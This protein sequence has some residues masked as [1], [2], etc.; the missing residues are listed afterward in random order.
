MTPSDNPEIGKMLDEIVVGV[1][2][3]GFYSV[4]RPLVDRLWPH[5]SHV[6]HPGQI[7]SSHFPSKLQS[8]QIQEFADEHKLNYRYDSI[9]KALVFRKRAEHEQTRPAEPPWEW[10]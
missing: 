5:P 9:T 10:D 2:E 1:E 6:L 3:S 8:E 7:F 4:L